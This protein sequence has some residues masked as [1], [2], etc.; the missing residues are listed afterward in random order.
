MNRTPILLLALWTAASSCAFAQSK[1]QATQPLFDGK[2]LQG[3]TATPGGQWEVRDGVIVGTSKKSERR[4]GILLTDREYS[5]FVVKAKFRVLTGDS[6]FYFRSER[7]KKGTAVNGFQV[8]VDSSQ[9]T[10]GLYETGGRAWVKKPS[11]EAISQRNYTP[12]KWTDLELT[13]LDGRIVVKING[14]VSAELENDKGRRKG[15]FGLQL[16]GG[17]DMHVEYKDLSIREVGEE[18]GFKEMFN[19]KDLTG[20]QTGGNW[21]V[22]KD[23]IITL[24]PRPGEH[25]WKRFEDYLT[26]KR[27]YGNFVLDLEFKFEAA[28]NSGVFMRIGDL[29][30][31]V[32]SG[33]EVQILDTHGKKKFGAHD[34]G[35][36]IGTSAPSKMVV[37]PAGEWNRYLITLQDNHLTVVLNGEQIQDLDLSQGALK[38]RPARG[39]ISFQDEAKRVWYRKVRIKAL[40]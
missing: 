26:T 10:G 32:K 1:E 3:W 35:G 2:T 20:W 33:F 11:A 40:P 13:A 8:E 14:V 34:C 6:G 22:E 37:K 38:D 16:H 27:E 23:N 12:G 18:D 4:H 5:N 9:E 15:H 30:D 19:G 39:R 17:Q 25:G 31:P 7:V 24:K 36:V 28:G 29:K 21:V